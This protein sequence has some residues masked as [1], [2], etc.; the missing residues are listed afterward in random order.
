MVPLPFY[1][2]YTRFLPKKY[3]RLHDYK[4]KHKLKSG[5]ENKTMTD[6]N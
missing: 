1:N 6:M 3:T 4:E 2:I 5:I